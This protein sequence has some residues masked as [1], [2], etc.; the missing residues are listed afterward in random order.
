MGPYQG[1]LAGEQAP[2]RG[3]SDGRRPGEIALADRPHGSD[4][5][6]AAPRAHGVDAV[7]RLHQARTADSRRGR[8]LGQEGH[9]VTRTKPVHVPDWMSRAEHGAM[10]ARLAARG[11][12]VRVRDRTKRV[13]ELVVATTLA[14]AGRYPAGGLGALCRR[15]R[16][17]AS[18]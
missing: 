13:R 6:I 5:M 10:P 14:G 8:R 2:L 7:I 12:R 15:R 3:L 18:N 9:V 17:A 1:E 11:P 16:D 4:W